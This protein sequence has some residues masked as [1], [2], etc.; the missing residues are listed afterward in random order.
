M[1][2]QLYGL[3]IWSE[4]S[5]PG[6]PSDHYGDVDVFV[7]FETPKK[8]IE[9]TSNCFMNWYLPEGELWLSFIKVDEGYLLRFNELADF[10]VDHCG[11]NIVCMPKFRT[12][13][14]IINHLLLNQVIPLVINLKGKEA[15]HASGV[16][17]SWGVIAFA[18]NPGSGKSTIAG[19]FFK[20]GNSLM[21]DDC[22]PL[23]EQSQNIYAVPAY[24]ELRLRGDSLGWFFGNVG[25]LGSGPHYKIKERVSI[26][27]DAKL[28]C[29]EIQPLKRVYT[30]TNL[31]ESKDK[32][33]IIIERLSPLKSL[34]ELIKYTFKLDITDHNM[35]KRQLDF[36]K[37]VVSTVPVRRLT[38]PRDFNLLPAVR[39]AIL[40]DLQDLDN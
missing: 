37:K 31:F 36:L 24:P 39:E 20:T 12:P 18:G 16:L 21:G 6:I 9:I 29:T 40:T 28:F 23:V 26:E 10:I 2:N 4:D 7:R 35:L 3:N 19:S 33:D 5:L 15:L 34:M 11:R 30:I 1:R 14:E 8:P 13:K 27:R 25:D 38:F 17:T 32:N 22:V